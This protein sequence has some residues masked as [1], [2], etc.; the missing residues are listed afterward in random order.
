MNP[1]IL[2]FG[3]AHPPLRMDTTRWLAL[4]T[5][6]A[7]PRVDRALL[8]R[9][10]DRSGIAQRWC[11]A[12]TDN[13]PAG[14]YAMHSPSAPIAAPIGTAARMRLWAEAVRPMALAACRD[15]LSS[16]GVDAQSVT[17][18]VTASCTGFCAPGM[19][20]WLIRDLDLSPSVRRTNIG[21]MGCHAA[22][23]AVASARD[24]AR[25]DP[26]ARVLVCCGEVCSAHLHYGER[27]DQWIANTLFGDGAAAIVISASADN[28]RSRAHAPATIIDTHSLII[29]GSQDAMTWEIGDCGFMMGLSAEVPAI[30]ERTL[31]KWVDAQL[32]VH[33]LARAAVAGWAIHP[34]G[35]RVIDSVVQ[36]LG[37]NAD[38]GDASRSVLR[39]FGN[40]SSATLLFILERLSRSG[41]AGPVVA[42]AF[43]PGLSAE[44]LVISVSSQSQTG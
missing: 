14:F 19:D 26:S 41:T 27:V 43:G 23:N 13:H 20:Q 36:A 4:A 39:D 8:Q 30:I 1:Q 32:A 18:L 33:G 3:C 21:F 34:G 5:A 16:S 35:P 17:H 37:L 15:A 22:I 28:A 7:P 31:P 12:A 9:L 38:A 29:E 42:L 24:I 6:I 40:M 2:G 44:M 25:A 10:A 11:A